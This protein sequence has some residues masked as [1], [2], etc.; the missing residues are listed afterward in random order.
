DGVHLRF[1]R[2]LDAEA[3]KSGW[4]VERW[5]YKWSGDY[6]SKRWSVRTPG[7]E[8]MDRLDVAAV[9]LDDDGKGVFLTVSDMRPAMQ[10]RVGHEATKTVIYSTVHRLEK[11]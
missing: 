8:G 2:K 10:M 3:V 7:R 9:K 5:D 6:G 11:R 1:G 4:L